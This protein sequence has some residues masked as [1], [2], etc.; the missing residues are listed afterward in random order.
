M[1]AHYICDDCG[2][3]FEFDESCIL[4]IHPQD[5]CSPFARMIRICADCAE[6]YGPCDDE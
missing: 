6:S 2:K 4:A 3:D 1:T 5:D